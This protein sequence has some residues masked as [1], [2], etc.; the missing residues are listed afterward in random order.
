MANIIITY[1]MRYVKT[2][3]TPKGYNPEGVMTTFPY[4][5]ELFIK[6]K[7]SITGTVIS[8]MSDCQIGRILDC[9]TISIND[10]HQ[11]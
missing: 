5:T 8:R 4:F 6:V 10:Q 3:M 7:H 9:Q 11:I 1:K 2:V